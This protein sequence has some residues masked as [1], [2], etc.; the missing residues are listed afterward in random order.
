MLPLFTIFG[1][2]I[3]TY[4]IMSLAGIFAAGIYVSHV[5][6]KSGYDDNDGIIFMLLALIG[7]FIGGHILYSIVNYRII[8]YAINNIETVKSFQDFLNIASLIWGGSVFYGGLFGGLLVA[9][10]VTCKRPQFGYLFDIAT[11]SIPLFHFFGRIGCFL[12]G[13]CFGIESSFG[14]TF[15][16]SI[17]EEAN[18]INRFPVQ[19]LEALFNLILFF[20]L[21][22]FRDK[23]MFK[24][25]L[26]YIYL[27]F[28]SIAR[29]FIEF[30]RGDKYRGFFLGLSTSQ[31]ISVLILCFV[32]PK[33]FSLFGMEK[34]IMKLP[35]QR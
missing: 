18:G 27:L 6:K 13:C 14:F 25:N 30:L 4:L 22:K 28:Y 3:G 15:R 32:V 24:Q 1:K 29:F 16:R 34:I 35:T 21:D 2:P 7:V 11:P 26:I 17:V 8:I 33:V 19:L 9:K 10:I 23:N 31:C 5:C 12:G 20:I